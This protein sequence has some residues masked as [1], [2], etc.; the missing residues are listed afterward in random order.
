MTQQNP[1]QF[2]P[3]P[4]VW[5]E[6]F[7]RGG[8]PFPWAPPGPEFW[9]AILAARQKKQPLEKKHA[10]PPNKKAPRDQWVK[11]EVVDKTTGEVTLKDAPPPAYHYVSA[12]DYV[13]ELDRVCLPQG[14]VVLQSAAL[15]PS[16]AG[17]TLVASYWVAHAGTGQGMVFRADTNASSSGSMGDPVKK[18]YTDSLAM[19]SRGFLAVSRTDM[20]AD[21]ETVYPYPAPGAPG[22]R[23]QA[24]P[25]TPPPPV[26]QSMGYPPGPPPPQPPFRA[27]P[28]GPGPQGPPQGT[29][30]G[31]QSHAPPPPQNLG[32]YGYPGGGVPGGNAGPP[33]PHRHMPPVQGAPPQ[34]PPP[35]N[36]G[37]P[38]GPHPFPASGPWPNPQPPSQATI[39]LMHEPVVQTSMQ[40]LGPNSPLPGEGPE[41]NAPPAQAVAQESAPQQQVVEPD[42]LSPP[43]PARATPVRGA[44]ENEPQTVEAW[45]DLLISKGWDEDMAANLA[46]LKPDEPIPDTLK[47]EIVTI[48]LNYYGTRQALLEGFKG[49]GFTPQPAL[50]DSVRP[51]PTGLQIMRFAANMNFENSTAQTG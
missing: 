32:P 40:L 1:G 51:K 37:H 23:M 41:R 14:L 4:E 18:A 44:R 28:P 39:P 42:L 47:E 3:D 38:G 5:K 12:D 45:S 2:A 50:P 9:Q 25:Q 19:F 27:P 21:E 49:T 36:D 48:G 11:V 17:K 30:P 46:A 10:G 24:P 34:G 13:D 8:Y 33:L 35:V 15:E 31:P 22:G 16:Q 43:P 7:F 6:A 26:Q 29:R 20:P